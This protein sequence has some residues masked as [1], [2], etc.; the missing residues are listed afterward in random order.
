M[1]LVFPMSK[2]LKYDVLTLQI[3]D[4]DEGV[5]A[6]AFKGTFIAFEGTFL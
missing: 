4:D 1:H 2:M 5:A 6:L 3:V